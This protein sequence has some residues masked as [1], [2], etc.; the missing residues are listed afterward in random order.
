VQKRTSTLVA[1][2]FGWGLSV[3][4]GF[5]C[6]STEAPAAGPGGGSGSVSAGSG[7]DSSSSGATTSAALCPGT[8]CDVIDDM[9]SAGSS[10][11]ND[12]ILTN[13]GR[14]GYWYVYNDGTVGGMQTPD[15]S[16]HSF[17]PDKI[18]PPRGASMYAAHTTGMGFTTWGAGFGF[19]I[20]NT[21]G[22]AD[23]GNGMPMPYDTT[24]FSYKGLY[25]FAKVGPTSTT[26]VRINLSDNLSN[27]AGMVCNP[28]STTK[29]TECS[30]DAGFTL[31]LT[32]DWQGYEVDFDT[33]SR[34][35][36]GPPGAFDPTS[37][38]YVHWQV[39]Q[40]NQ[41]DIWIDDVYFVK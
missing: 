38:Y 9:E 13:E 3:A 23:G 28:N 25:F 18:V 16:T 1:L 40:N 10:T 6:G 11:M 5:A 26:S 27:P 20:N 39:T 14:S 36:F 4:G 33:L 35:G 31:T 15:P 34:Q 24:K 7:S 21:G 12:G 37:L 41:F 8:E 2:G 30:D 29:G 22:G 19:D 17:V 32:N